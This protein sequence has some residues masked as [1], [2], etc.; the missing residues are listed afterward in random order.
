MHFRIYYDDFHLIL[1]KTFITKELLQ[2]KA[3]CNRIHNC[4][5][6]NKNRFIVDKDSD[7]KHKRPKK[8]K[9]FNNKVFENKIPIA[10]VIPRYDA[11]VVV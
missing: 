4:E 8:Q 7:K 6:L 10:F 5:M 1:S 2:D 11:F 3:A 9:P